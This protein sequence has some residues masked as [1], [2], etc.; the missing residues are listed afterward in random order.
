MLKDT[1]VNSGELAVPLKQSACKIKK[2]PFG[3]PSVK[4]KFQKPLSGHCWLPF[5]VLKV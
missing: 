3:K 5:N 1:K 4:L 2:E